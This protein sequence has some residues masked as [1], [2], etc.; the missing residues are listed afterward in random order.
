MDFNSQSHYILL[1]GRWYYSKSLEDGDWTFREPGELPD[2]FAKIPENSDMVSVRASI[3]GTEEA[4]T[5]LLEQSIPQ[6]AT[7]DQK[8][9][10]VDVKYDGE[11]QFE[12]IEGTSMSYALN[13]DKSVLLIDDIFYCPD[14][15]VWFSSAK[16]NDLW[17]VCVV[18]PD[19]VD[20]LPPESPVYNVK[21][22]YIYESTPK[23]YM[24]VTCPDILI[25]M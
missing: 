4:Q 16:P 1:A 20:D 11:P 14:D 7:I 19:E 5:A 13:T 17:K 12:K 22:T 15:A 2:D 9:A 10:S 21:Y 25:V 8:K 6:T 24:W 3:P 23:W 18:C